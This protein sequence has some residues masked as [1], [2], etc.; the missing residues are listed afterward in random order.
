M[1]SS[2]TMHLMM[3][4]IGST[5]KSM[6]SAIL[7]QYLHDKSVDL[8]IVSTWQNDCTL[9]N[10]E[11]LD[12]HKLR[13]LNSQSLADQ[14]KF[15]IFTNEFID[16]STNMLIDTSSNDFLEIDSYMQSNRISEIFLENDKKLVIHCPIVYGQCGDEARKCLFEIAKC[17]PNTPI[18]VWENEF[19]GS[20]DSV[21][22]YN[23]LGIYKN[24]IGV[25][26]IN[27]VPKTIGDNAYTKMLEKF[28][29]FNEVSESS[30][31]SFLEKNALSAI[32]DD[33]YKQLD[34]VFG[35]VKLCLV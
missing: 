35:R 5:G 26:K 25:V 27:K 17:Y 29:L 11:A 30:N 22:D 23:P 28:M 20:N 12:V 34:E 7:A 9:F 16:E 24:I 18:V 4:K 33:I 13:T 1:N 3:Q 6:F 8:K 15:D 14:S 32:K 19:F 10:Y 31:F 2:N 21:I